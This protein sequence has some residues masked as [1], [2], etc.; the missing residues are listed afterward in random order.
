MTRSQR[1]L[2][3]VYGGKQIAPA[4]NR[5]G[6][7]FIVASPRSRTGKTFLAQ[8]LTDFLSIDGDD[9]QAFDLNPSE[10]AL[11]EC[12]PAVTQKLNLNTTQDQVALFDRLIVNDG[13]AKVVDVG[14]ASYERFVAL[15]EEIGFI[16]E[17]RRRSLDVTLLYA[18]DQRPASAE[19]YR[20]FQQRFPNVA[21]VP[22]FNQAI[23]EG[24]K[25]RED[26]RFARRAGVPLQIAYLPP[27]L[28]AI[29]DKSGYSFADFHAQLPSAI[30]IG[31]G[32]ELRSWTRRAF[33]EFRELE[34]R[35]LL[36]KLRASLGR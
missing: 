21:L 19:A 23:V 25:V 31:D 26:Y 36:E 18:A 15:I 29:A 16:E 22:V 20:Q 10:Y 1:A 9:V 2:A 11:A 32:L 33:L 5:A 35:L 6:Q 7:I 17:A 34:L 27:V 13:I 30:P 14:Q 12:R 4:T 8:L 28:K 24:Q 3:A